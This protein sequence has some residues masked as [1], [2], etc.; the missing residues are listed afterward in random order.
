MD[1]SCRFP[2]L[3]ECRTSDWKDANTA[4]PEADMT[5]QK[6]VSGAHTLLPFDC[7][8]QLE[9]SLCKLYFSSFRKPE[10]GGASSREPR[11]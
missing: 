11:D 6:G 10:G 2:K 3:I 5:A 8:F 4:P 9:T 1:L 7:P